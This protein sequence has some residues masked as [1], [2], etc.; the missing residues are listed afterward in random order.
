MSGAFRVLRA[1][2]VRLCTSRTGVVA[3]LLLVLVPALRVWAAGLA[4]RAK[5]IERAATGAEQI[6]LTE[7]T[8]WAMLVDGWRAGLMLGTA[9]LLVQGARSIAGDRETGVLRLAVTRS[10]SRGGAVVGRA[11]LGPIL[12]IFTVALAGIGAYLAT[13]GVGG[14]FGDLIEDDFTIFLGAEVRAELIRSLVP[15]AAGL[16]AVHAFGLLISSL[17]RGP[18]LALAG[19]LAAILLW[20]V[21]KEDMGESR[22]YVFATHAP[23]FADGSAMKEL[24]GF[25]RAYSDAGLPDA[26][27]N[28]GMILPP[29]QAVVF[30]GLAVLALR[31]RP[32]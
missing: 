23:T 3:G 6:G 27:I 7:G 5:D 14:D 17:S 12:V 22:F 9:L 15:V 4:A 11:L 21:F 29:I 24:A 2:F 16:V 8:G 26:V 30:V 1:E 31:K 19:S 10:A 20:D 32:I 25:A 28:M 13:K 18:V